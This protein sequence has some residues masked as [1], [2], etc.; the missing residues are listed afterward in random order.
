MAATDTFSILNLPGTSADR[1]KLVRMRA[2]AGAGLAPRSSAAEFTAS[3]F[4][5]NRWFVSRWIYFSMLKPFNS[6][7]PLLFALLA[8]SASTRSAPPA[9]PA[10]AEPQALAHAPVARPVRIG[11]ALG[12]GA[13]RGF[14]HIGV[15]KALEAQ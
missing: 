7:A 8:G 12:G 2:G 1:R 13:A 5:Y 14:A 3:K 10:A 15:I 11:L 9:A 4:R 6:L